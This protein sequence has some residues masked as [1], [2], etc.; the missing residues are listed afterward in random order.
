MSSW[1][2]P[3]AADSFL[4]L[5][6]P[7]C[8]ELESTK[9]ATFTFTQGK[10][11]CIPP[12][13]FDDYFGPPP[14]YR[15]IEYDGLQRSDVL[16][17]IRDFPEA[18]TAEDTL[19]ELLSEDEETHEYLKLNIE[20]AFDDLFRTLDELGPFDG[21]VGYSEG[22]TVAATLILEEKRRFEEE[23]RPRQ[24]KC[25]V[26]FAG[27]PPL[28]AGGGIIL[29]DVD[30]EVIDVPTCH[31]IGARDPYLHGAMALYN[32]SNADQARLF[33]HGKGHTLPRDRKTIQELA[34]V[35]KDT[36][37]EAMA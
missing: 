27:W 19:R 30:G 36:I 25:G 9:I 2:R 21:V 31:I 14:H 12:A 24:L 32:V 37:E 15:F 26:F 17:R 33:D 10:N 7:F 23:G 5:T 13:G 3:L 22:A 29:A 16:E 6:A 34:E 8:N 1:F 28:K 35:V 20:S 18:A 11:T 4:C